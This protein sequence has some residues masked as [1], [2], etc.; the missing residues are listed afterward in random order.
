VQKHF[1]VPSGP[2]GDR[3]SI[4]SGYTL[5]ALAVRE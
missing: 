5:A 3:R 4:A 2:N 1:F